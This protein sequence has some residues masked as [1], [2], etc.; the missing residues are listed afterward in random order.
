M[1]TLSLRQT[2]LVKLFSLLALALTACSTQPLTQAEIEQREFRE[3]ERQIEEQERREAYLHWYHQCT[4]HGGIVCFKNVRCVT[5]IR[6]RCI[7]TKY[8]WRGDRP[9]VSVTCAGNCLGLPH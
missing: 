2:K 3:L 8:D 7:P 4:S 5:G 6:E 1:L 9:S